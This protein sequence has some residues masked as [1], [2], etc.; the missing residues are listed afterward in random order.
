MA[1]RRMKDEDEDEMRTTAMSTP[2]F[3]GRYPAAKS[4]LETV[5]PETLELDSRGAL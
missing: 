2:G 1:L 3:S 5:M 4:D